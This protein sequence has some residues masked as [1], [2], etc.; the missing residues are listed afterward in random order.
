MTARHLALLAAVLFCIAM[1][2]AGAAAQE[3]AHVQ[4]EL[5]LDV[6]DVRSPDRGTVQLGAGLAL[7]LGYYARLGLIGAGGISR[8]RGGE[9][10]SARA[11]VLMR[12]L[13]DP[14]RE[15]RYGVSVGGG[16]SLRY[17]RAEGWQE[18]L[19]IVVDVE[20]PAVHS[21]VPA[22]QVG[23]GGGVRIG[24]GLRRAQHGRR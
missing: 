6:I 22:L 2:G 23:L 4:P 16:L 12:F 14:F 3:P 10:G 18:Y 17:A 13:I 19:A 5:R 7:P 11:D 9:Q 20:A 8:E 15:T 1:P 24:V 21:I